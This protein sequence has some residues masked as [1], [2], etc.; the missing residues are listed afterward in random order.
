[1]NF[2]DLIWL[3]PLFPLC[4]AALML[5]AGKRLDPQPASDVAVAPGVAPAGGG[6]GGAHDRARP[7][8]PL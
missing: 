7:P 1:M 2:L 4:G 6:H 8:S 3:I 5:L